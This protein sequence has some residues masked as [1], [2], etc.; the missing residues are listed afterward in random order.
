MILRRRRSPD[1]G[2]SDEAYAGKTVLVQEKPLLEAVTDPATA[3]ERMVAIVMANLAA[4][5]ERAGT[6]GRIVEHPLGIVRKAS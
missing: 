4:E 2:R 5:D 6:A 1:R 3:Q